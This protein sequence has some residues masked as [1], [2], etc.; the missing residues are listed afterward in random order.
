MCICLCIAV[1]VIVS[2]QMILVSQFLFP[3]YFSSL[4]FSHSLFSLLILHMILIAIAIFCVCSMQTMKATHQFSCYAHFIKSSIL[5]AH[6][7][8]IWS[9]D[10]NITNVPL[11]LSI[12]CIKSQKGQRIVNKNQLIEFSYYFPFLVFFGALS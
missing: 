6:I 3:F 11:H 10:A 1:V 9:M 7:T 2:T 8:R 5:P 4:P 12:Y